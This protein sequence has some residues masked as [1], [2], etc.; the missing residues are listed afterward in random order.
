VQE[1]FF[2]R[3]L[4]GGPHIAHLSF[5]PSHTAISEGLHVAIGILSKATD[6]NIGNVEL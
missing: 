2:I 4:L 1:I 5:K 3:G 6:I